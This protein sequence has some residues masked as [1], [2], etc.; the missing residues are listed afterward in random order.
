[1]T[2]SDGPRGCRCHPWARA[3]LSV[4]WCQAHAGRARFFSLLTAEGTEP[5]LADASPTPLSRAVRG[6]AHEV[7]A[8]AAH[9]QAAGPGPS[10]ASASRPFSQLLLQRFH[11]S[12]LCRIHPNVSSLGLL[13]HLPSSYASQ[14]FQ[15]LPLLSGQMCPLGLLS[16]SHRPGSEPVWS[17]TLPNSGPLL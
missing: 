7:H 10:S 2:L 6:L 11:S 4:T 9:G 13:L 17:E 15:L 1:M 3:G 12:S 16:L 14:P 8:V 5:F